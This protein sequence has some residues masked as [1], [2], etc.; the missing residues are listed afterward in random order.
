MSDKTSNSKNVLISDEENTIVQDSMS[1]FVRFQDANGDKLPDVC[2]VEIVPPEKICKDCVP[3]PMAISKNWRQTDQNSPFLNEKIC[4]YQITFK[5]NET[6]TGFA[7]GMTEAESE[8]ALNEMYDKYARDAAI[9]L[10]EEFQ[11]DTSEGTVIRLLSVLENTNFY[12]EPRNSSR[13]LLQYSVEFTKFSVLPDESI[14]SEDTDDEAKESGDVEVSYEASDLVTKQ[15]RIRKGINLYGRFAKVAKAVEG[16]KIRF[17]ESNKIFSL[18][19]YGDAAL[20]T[21]PSPIG[22]LVTEL[23]KFL[24]GKGYNIAAVGQLG[25]LNEKVIKL[26]FVFTSEY[27]LKKLKVYTE[28]CGSKRPDIVY[29]KKFLK[30]LN[31]KEAWKDPTAIA[32]FAQMDKIESAITAR[33]PMPF[34]EF[35]V[36]FTYP[37]VFIEKSTNPEDSE[38]AAK[39]IDSCIRDALAN[40]F[41]ELGQDIFDDVFSLADAIAYKFHKNLCQTDPT[42]IDD[43]AL[44]KGLNI[45]AGPGPTSNI[46]GMAKSQAYETITAQDSAFADLCFRMISIGSSGVQCGV[47]PIQQL[48]QMYAEGLD[49]I[50]ICGLMDLFLEALQ[51]LFKGLT[52]EE[53]LASI[54]RSALSAMG[55]TQIGDLFIGLPPE[56]QAELEALVNQ[57]LESGD[58][59]PPDSP[60]QATSDIIAK[61]Q[62]A[63]DAAILKKFK[64]KKPWDD[65]N[66]AEQQNNN[67]R[68]DNYGNM[69]PSKSPNYSPSDEPE[70]RTIGQKLQEPLG[71]SYQTNNIILNAY[72][73]AFLEAY[74][75]NLLE[76]VDLL[77]KF[78]GAQLIA[79]LIIFLDCPTPPLFNPGFD[80]FFKSLQLPFCRNTKPIV[81]PKWENPFLY[82]PK[83]TDILAAIFEALRKLVLCIIMRVII[84]ILSK[85]CEIVADA[86]CK[87]LEV[88]GQIGAGLLTGN[89]DVREIMRET[90]C[91]PNA[92]DEEID[93]SVLELMENFGVGGAAFADPERTQSFF[94]D[95]INS[96]T[97]QEA[98]G[99]FI[100]GPQK[101]EVDVLDGLIDTRYPEFRNALP[102]K[103]ACRRMLRGIVNVTPAST[104]DEIRD[105]RNL[106]SDDLTLPINPSLCSTQEQRD[107]FDKIK[108]DLLAGRMS[109]QD[110]IQQNKALLDQTL[111]D[112]GDVNKI[113]NE[114]INSIL[115][116]NM[117]P[118][119]SDPGC[120]NGLLPFE[121][122]ESIKT[123]TGVLKGDL[124]SLQIAYTDDMLGNGGLFAGDDDWGM[125]NMILSDT[126]ANPYTAH[127][128]KTSNN[129][130]FVDFYIPNE[131]E[132]A[133]GLPVANDF[134][135]R[136]AY[137]HYVAEWLKY[138]YTTVSGAQD[139]QSSL[140]GRSY[141]SNNQV[142][143]PIVLTKTFKDL[144]F[145][146]L[147]D[148]DFNATEITDYGYN[149]TLKVNFETEKVRIT[150]EARKKT[151][152]IVLNYKDNSRGYRYD[153]DGNKI[154]DN[155]YAYGFELEAY[156]SDI[157]EV[158]ND[159]G[160]GYYNIP[161]DNIRIK[162]TESINEK[163]KVNAALSD[164][165]GNAD[166]ASEDDGTGIIT[167]LKYE[168]FAIDDTFKN[169]DVNPRQYPLL[170]DAFTE[171]LKPLEPQAYALSDLTGISPEN[172]K[173]IYESFSSKMYRTI[174][175][176]IGN[177][178]DVWLYGAKFDDLGK[179]DFEYGII[180]T[181]EYSQYNPLYTVGAFIPYSQFQLPVYNDDGEILAGITR[182]VENDD[183]ILGISYDAYINRNNPDK[184]RVHYLNPIQFGQ[185]YKSPSFYVKPVKNKGWL[186]VV[187][188]MFPEYNAC[189]P[190]NSNLIAFDDIM[191]HIDDSYARIPEDKRLKTDPDCVFEAPFNRILS[192][193]SRAGLESIITALIRIFASTHFIKSLPV[194]GTFEPKFPENYSNIFASYIIENMEEACINAGNNFLS[195]FKDNEFWYAFLEQSVQVY[196]RRL[197]DDLDDSITPD[198]VPIHVKEAIEKINQLQEKYD[199][200]SRKEFRDAPSNEKSN[201]QSLKS[202]REEKILEAVREVEEECKLILLEL[203]KEQLSFISNLFKQNMKE[204]N[205]APHVKNLDYYFIQSFANGG[206]QLNL[207]DSVE[208]VESV[209]SEP[210]TPDSSGKLYT[211]GNEFALPDGT[212]Y[213][214]YFHIHIDSEGNKIYMVGE[215]HVQEA[216]SV[217]VPYSYNTV[218]QSKNSD[219]EMTEIIDISD[220]TVGV[221]KQFYIRKYVSIN[222]SEYTVDAAESLIRG[223]TTGNISDHYPGTLELLRNDAGQPVGLIGE[224]GVKNGI[225]FG[226]NNSGNRVPITRVE[227]DA[228][229]LDVSEYSGPKQNSKLLLCLV[230]NLRDEPRFRMVVDYI[231]SMKKALSV[232]AIYTDI[233]FMPS[234]GE[235]TQPKRNMFIPTFSEAL[236]SGKPGVYVEL[237]EDNQVET[238][239][240][241]GWANEADRNG[242]FA[243]PFY[244]K[245]DEWDQILLRK[246]VRRVK[247]IFRP[248]YTKRKFEVEDDTDAGP[249]TQFLNNAKARFKPAPANGAIPWFKRRKLK[250]NPFN[251]KGQLCKKSN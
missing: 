170:Y 152:N 191:K 112:V 211:S 127:Q 151:P 239:W 183:S 4:K 135:Q 91:G 161:N 131:Q 73:E 66:F 59:F 207:S 209:V 115:E 134:L 136:G 240:N 3:N 159:A 57:K 212:P 141:T 92:S 218:V 133:L 139:L 32:Y 168:F 123:A 56:K 13:L 234:I 82:I 157:H 180:N 150:K 62:N 125:I 19:D 245:W 22:E 225:E 132:E 77:N 9:S 247:K 34:E 95:F 243:S 109:P 75:D 21:K 128:R 220:S 153:Y 205:L 219:G 224:L 165:I 81:F 43:D 237:G 193:P 194:F 113:M 145:S 107:N 52:L 51:C 169:I 12:L 29:G 74:K 236:A 39:S 30:S 108:C 158:T 217:L 203:V 98:L 189:R 78:P 213:F 226:I 85:V 142:Q 54:V 238:G 230:D 147:F 23:D 187:N 185:N 231:F 93:N 80:D 42:K 201:F 175:D 198:N 110:C 67:K 129:S 148:T 63:P 154:G 14:D 94:G 24:N 244:R 103:E 144:G 5:T 64:N 223:N 160:S 182:P 20:F 214:G 16:K 250:P 197:D 251:S 163:A 28:G 176:T 162:I 196:S 242:F 69:T 68:A 172:C 25:L 167:N 2:D 248:Y 143:D 70:R 60:G 41:K 215:Q 38:K 101:I 88:A 116:D 232:H 229:D 130:R 174:K 49:R 72:I 119:F 235:F 26:D 233:G 140:V 105:A 27:K 186:G 102:N 204:A 15:I 246:S 90:I 8:A 100:D 114:G 164:K 199:Q 96:L 120:E 45:A 149:T 40:D 7:E 99:M 44:L 155:K 210:G 190:R 61:K 11:K 122:E 178:E 228:L 222:G 173:N 206:E 221:D 104:V 208:L 249:G 200:P 55:V 46:Y 53:A 76:L 124:E 86:I 138:Q 216:H 71:E 166:E 36:E 18:S 137:P 117:P 118:I 84:L 156:Y 177:N 181:S 83:L 195:P 17:T 87:A 35:A 121:P 47:S 58:I 97:R 79:S 89:T 184:I 111:E 241:P 6:T 50:A 33:V 106:G 188:L 179:K 10:L 146:G 126:F 171:K 37:K 65:K 202:Y 1:K 227:I 48:D 31:S 192:R